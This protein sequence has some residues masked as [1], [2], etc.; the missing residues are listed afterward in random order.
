VGNETLT[1]TGDPLEHHDL[2]PAVVG[3]PIMRTLFLAAL[4]AGLSIPALAADLADVPLRGTQY[5]SAHVAI[6]N[7]EG[8]YFGGF[9]G[10]GA[11]NV[12]FN[13]AVERIVANHFRDTVE[14]RNG[15]IS[16]LHNIPDKDSRSSVFGVFGG[17]NVQYDE[18]VL[19]VEADYTRGRFSAESGEIVRREL[20]M[21]TG[22]G[23]TTVVSYGSARLNE[24]ATLRARAGYT[25]GAF[26]P[27]V[28]AGVALGR[29]DVA[30]RS[31]VVIDG[32]RYGTPP[33]DKNDAFSVGLAAGLGV[34][35]AV[36]Q[37]L[38]VRGEWQYIH[39]R[40]FARVTASVNTVRAAAGLKF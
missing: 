20:P 17:Y 13:G 16:T 33:F 29:A 4:T 21:P 36:T 12:G 31:L 5:G 14:D 6:Q 32:L 10:L 18:I 2:D 37:N 8:V 25:Y 40:D 19:G 24:V 27:Y 26:M 35:V 38:F 3:S 34:D 1:L 11:T 28:T 22:L 23:N 39:F 9:A 30:L 15:Q 7:W